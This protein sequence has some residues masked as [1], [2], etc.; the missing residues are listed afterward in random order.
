ML[1]EGSH[2]ECGDSDMPPGMLA[3]P[4]E[5]QCLCTK[6]LTFVSLSFLSVNRGIVNV[7]TSQGDSEK[8]KRVNPCGYLESSLAQSQVVEGFVVIIL[9]DFY[10]RALCDIIRKLRIRERKQLFQGHTA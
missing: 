1:F 6:N 9:L 4:L 10:V 5:S 8:K 3:L 2:K 7:C